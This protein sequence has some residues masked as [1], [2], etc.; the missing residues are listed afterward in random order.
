MTSP[1]LTDT[2]ALPEASG[3]MVQWLGLTCQGGRYA[4]PLANVAAVFKPKPSTETP[5]RLLDIEVHDGAPVF[6]RSFQDS[7]ALLPSPWKDASLEDH[8]WVLVLQSAGRSAVGF[9]MSHVV[10]PFWASAL[11]EHVSH[12]GLQWQA[13]SVPETAES[14]HA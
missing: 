4:L 11:S 12:D 8:H 6:I 10:G 7:F 5:Q 14:F 9:R 2:S 3:A 1:S 13:L